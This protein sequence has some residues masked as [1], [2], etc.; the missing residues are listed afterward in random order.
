MTSI[1]PIYDYDD[2]EEESQP[3]SG[4]KKIHFYQQQQVFEAVEDERPEVLCCGDK[5]LPKIFMMIFGLG[6]FVGFIDYF[7]V[8]TDLDRKF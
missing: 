8:K 3:S 7:L 1:N 5:K 2:T 4:K 6:A